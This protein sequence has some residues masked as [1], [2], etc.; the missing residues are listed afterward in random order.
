MRR[1]EQWVFG[2]V[3]VRLSLYKEGTPRSDFGAIH[4]MRIQ[5]VSKGRGK[6]R[7]R[8]LSPSSSPPP[9]QPILL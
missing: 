6:R 4:W 3:P 9:R 1:Q 7:A 2:I 8:L 5:K